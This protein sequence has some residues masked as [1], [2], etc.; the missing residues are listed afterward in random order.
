MELFDAPQNSAEGTAKTNVPELSVSELAFS[1]K[2]T[3][4]ETYGR[5]RVRGELSRVKIHSSGHL[6]SDLKDADAVLNVVCWRSTLSR[7]NIRPEEGLDVICTGKITSY[8]A[9][10]NYQMVIEKMELAGEGALLKLLEE[11]KKRLAAEGL[12]DAERK[13]PIPVLPQTIGVI[14]SPTGA[15]IRDI[16]HRV[17]DRFPRPVYLWP[18]RVQGDGAAEEIARAIDG[19]NNLPENSGIPTPDVLIVARGGGS[20]EDLMPFNEE[21]V[22]RAAANSKIPLISAVGHETD[23]TLIDFA[24]DLRAPTPTA[25]AELAVPERAA[26]INTLNDF[27]TRLDNSLSHRIKREKDQLSH[28]AARLGDPN[29][30][31][32]TKSQKFDHLTDQLD[33]AM[34]RRINTASQLLLRLAPR[35]LHPGQMIAMAR[36]NLDHISANLVKAEERIMERH[37]QTLERASKMLELL[38]FKSTLSRG[39]AVIRDENRTPLTR[40]ENIAVGQRLSIELSDGELK[41]MVEEKI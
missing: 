21:V 3:L 27:T 14:T 11:R 9:R 6:Y 4:E 29:R 13:R 2:R 16:L 38:S 15:V 5:V 18:V 30:L 39:F 24:A 8:P 25:A 23:T 17:G 28:F 1:L 36:K 20:L 40:T 22:V 33:N 26:L 32:E 41:T 19:F 34:E 37:T 10:S 31:L 12:F 7:L 35:L